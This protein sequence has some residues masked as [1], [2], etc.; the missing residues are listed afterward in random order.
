MLRPFS[1]QSKTE[2]T[3]FVC[4]SFLR[5]LLL[6]VALLQLALPPAQH[7]NTVVSVFY[8]VKERV[9]IAAYSY[10]LAHHKLSVNTIFLIIFK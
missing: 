5:K 2:S 3:V 1:V 6:G 4:Q 10:N 7:T 9:C 8:L